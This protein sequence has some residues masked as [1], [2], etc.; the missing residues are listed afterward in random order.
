MRRKK[1][2]GLCSRCWFRDPTR[3]ITQA[4]NLSMRLAD[5]PEWLIRFAAFAAE[6][7]CAERASGMITAVGRLI[8]DGGPVQPQA[9]LERARRP[10]R[11]AGALARTLEEFFLREGLA[12]G[13]D[14][15]ARLAHGRRQRRVGTAPSSLRPG[16][17]AFCE[18]LVRSN[19]RARRA[20]TRP[21][22]DSTIE[23]SLAIIRDLA[24][25]LVARCDKHDWAAVEVADIERFL[26]ER[27]RNRRRR[28]RTTHQFFRWAR[29]NRLVLVDPTRD[30]PSVPRGAFGGRVLS[31]AEQRRLFR[32]WSDNDSAHPHEA[33]VGL[34]ALLHALSSAELRHLRADDVDLVHCTLS[35]AGRRHRVPLDPVTTSALRRCLEHRA[36]LGSENPHLIVTKITKTRSTA[37]ST[38][39]IA[40]VLDPAG[41]TPKLVRTTRIVSLVHRLDPKVA[42]EALGMNAEGLVRYIAE[43]VVATR[44]AAE[45][46]D[47]NL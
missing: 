34:L 19:E 28:L 27:P 35:V 7:R 25:F 45:A 43:D 40:H 26:A 3:P 36:S 32:R 21:R 11:S 4:L 41:V 2:D 13:L 44:L 15:E 38:P 20:G 22:A 33:L 39:Y 30:L 1:G 42:S 18:H 29:K 23:Q 47:M 6:R 14:Q 10:G 37:A 9:L 12:F 46:L 31:A 16:L 17:A 8:E 24:C 5:S